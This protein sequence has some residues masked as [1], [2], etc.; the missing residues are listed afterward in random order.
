MKT[1]LLVTILSALTTAAAVAQT[2][3][4]P[5]SGTRVITLG[6]LAGP[7][8]RA[9]RAQTSNLLT[10]NG[11]LYV[12]DAGDG[13][14]RR[15]AKAGVNLRDIGVV[16]ITHHHDDHTAGLGTLLSVAWDQN[17]TEPIHVYGPPGTEAL[18]K[19][20]VQYFTLS[21]E[22]R[23]ADGGRSVP[24]A[25]LFFGH[26]VAPGAVYQDKNIKVTAAENTHYSFHKGGA[27]GK[28][29]SYAYRFETPDRIVVFTGD[30]GPSDAV[31][32]L[33]SGADLLVAE[34]NSIEDRKQA[35][36]N[37]G[38]WQ[39][40]SEKERAGILQQAARGHLTPKDIAE[41]ASRAKVKTVV[42]THLTFRPPPNT[43]H[44]DAW[45]AEVKKEFSGTVLVAKDLMEF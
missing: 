4:P 17:R 21:S 32:Q 41:M 26:D 40:M 38:R 15:L 14:V 42:L 31:T 8:P 35:M 11:A 37:D 24:I 13:V 44:Y 43:D 12:V 20:A 33:A 28:F 29:K 10:V 18:V 16:F 19:A 9:H 3:E 5:K 23:I 27:A 2:R 39:A 25:Q 34:V 7:P 22:I 6:T 36:I 30:T 45:A 1:L